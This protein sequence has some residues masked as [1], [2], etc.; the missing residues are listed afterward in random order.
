MGAEAVMALMDA[1][2]SSEPCVVSL[3]GNQAVRLP[4]MACVEKTKAVAK[5]MAERNWDLAV[6]L[7]GRYFAITDYNHYPFQYYFLL[8]CSNL[9]FK[10]FCRSFQRNLDTFKMLTRLKPPKAALDGEG[11]GLVRSYNYMSTFCELARRLTFSRN[12]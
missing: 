2:P 1:M 4:L 5:A 11:K 7:R 8:S 3:D 6:Q 10:Y 9:K 12:S